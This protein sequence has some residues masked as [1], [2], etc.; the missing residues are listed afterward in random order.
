M[1]VRV[2]CV[3]VYHMCAG[4]RG[5]QKRVSGPLKLD[6][7]AVVSHLGAGNQTQSLSKSSKCS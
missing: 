1:C 4:V 7:Q 5:N 2:E 6:L 3:Y